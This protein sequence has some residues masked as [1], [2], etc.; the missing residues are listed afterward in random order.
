MVSSSALVLLFGAAL[1]PGG[2]A[3]RTKFVSSQ[4]QGKEGYLWRTG[5]DLRFKW[6]DKPITGDGVTLIAKVAPASVVKGWEFNSPPKT[7]KNSVN[8]PAE[9]HTGFENFFRMCRQKGIT[10]TLL[11]PVV[12]L[13][14]FNEGQ[15][16]TMV[17]EGQ[18]VNIQ[19]Y[20]YAGII[21]GDS[22]E[23]DD[24][25]RIESVQWLVFK[26]AIDKSKGRVAKL[27]AYDNLPK[28]TEFHKEYS[29]TSQDTE[30]SSNDI[31]E[32]EKPVVKE[33]TED[34]VT[35][36]SAATP[37]CYLYVEKVSGAAGGFSLNMMYSKDGS[38]AT[39]DKVP[40]GFFEPS[41]AKVA[42][43]SWKYS[44]G[45]RR[46]LM[47]GTMT[48][49]GLANVKGFLQ[50]YASFINEGRKMEGKFTLLPNEKAKLKVIFHNKNGPG[51]SIPAVANE[52]ADLM[53]KDMVAVLDESEKELDKPGWT[54]AGFVEQARKL[55]Y[56]FSWSKD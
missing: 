54:T 48:S 29:A 50:H 32:D 52:P 6:S 39:E 37:G 41:Q 44:N 16:I 10:V 20:D 30:P 31:V 18:S 7:I 27:D 22:D 28:L 8:Y 13:F 17:T 14:F 5:N 24:L 40:I 9:M 49:G 4:M 36:D 1:L 53:D 23:A 26:D 25:N 33:S 45:N 42:L 21:E 19:E 56:L 38:F 55:G 47:R 34:I 3:I 43:N 11:S 35:S 2:A 46:T 15:P 51:E 12:K